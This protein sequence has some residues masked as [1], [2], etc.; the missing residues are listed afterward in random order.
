MVNLPRKIKA[1]L[2]MVAA[3]A[4]LSAMA[5]SGRELSS[6][7]TIFQILFFRS[8]A[9]LVII[10]II[11]QKTGWWQVKTNR[12][13]IQFIRNILHYG[14]QYGWFYG[15]AL[16]PL[17]KVFAIEFTT[18]IWIMLIAMIMLGEKIDRY[19]IIAVIL[20]F[21][22]ILIILRPGIIPMSIASFAVLLCAFCY[23]MAHSLTKLLTN[24]KDSP[25]T[26]IF[27]MTV[28]QLPIG[29]IAIIGDWVWPSLLAWPWVIILA[30]T[31][32]SAH[33][34]I[35][36]AFMLADATTVMPIDFLR[37]PLII[38]L[39]FLFYNEII[40]ILTVVGAA[41]VFIGSYMTIYSTTT[42]KS[43]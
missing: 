32:L 20:G 35:A 33:F 7:L 40:D 37:L 17:S 11:L 14:G 25:V 8:L 38:L 42:D 41:I 39:G 29:F 6:E 5:I 19:K 1:Y 12:P 24:S 43:D 16:L 18:P 23:A 2:W 10:L 26:I 36:R 4:S 28:I 22:G 31:A 30:I 15:I 9:G 21:I 34:S 27:Y 13:A 3:L